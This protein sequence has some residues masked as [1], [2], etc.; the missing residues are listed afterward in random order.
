MSNQLKI[1]HGGRRAYYDSKK[2]EVV[3]PHPDFFESKPKYLLTLFH[4][5]AHATGHKTGLYRFDIGWQHGTRE[6][7]FEEIVAE[8]SAAFLGSEI[9][10]EGL[11]DLHS[12]YVQRVIDP[13]EN[14][15]RHILKACRRSIQVVNYI[16]NRVDQPRLF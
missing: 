8:L 1:V 9:G 13:L 6:R 2:D 15:G 11:T 5:L 4:E 10:I 16:M 14:D 7:A 3:M 12:A